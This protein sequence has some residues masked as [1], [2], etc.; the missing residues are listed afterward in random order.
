MLFYVYVKTN[1]ALF[2]MWHQNKF[3]FVRCF[4]GC[5]GFERVKGFAAF[6]VHHEDIYLH[7]T[8]LSN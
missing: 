3:Q 6:N 2:A 7:V 8:S 5:G 1:W 4:I